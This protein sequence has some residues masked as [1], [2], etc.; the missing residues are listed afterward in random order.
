MKFNALVAK[1]NW[2]KKRSFVLQSP[3]ALKFLIKTRSFNQRS[4]TRQST[5]LSK[6]SLI[7]NSSTGGKTTVARKFSTKRV[8]ATIREASRPMLHTLGKRGSGTDLPGTWSVH[9]L[10]TRLKTISISSSQLMSIKTVRFQ[11]RNLA[12]RMTDQYILKLIAN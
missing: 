6:T 12:Q 7:L 2:G 5:L 11:R 3:R 1:L 4:G 9:S 8:L 10:S